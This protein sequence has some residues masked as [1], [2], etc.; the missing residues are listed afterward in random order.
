MGDKMIYKLIEDE[1]GNFKDANNIKYTILEA[2]DYIDDF[3]GRNVNVYEFN[4][5]A[6]AM[7]FFNVTKINQE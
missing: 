7:N 1:N 5:L 4:S 2:E 3:E 6:E